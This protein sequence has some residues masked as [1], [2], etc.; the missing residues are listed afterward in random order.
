MTLILAMSKPEGV[1]MSVDYRVTDMRSG[2]LVDDASIKFLP[3]RYPPDKGGPRALLAY[4][5][6]ARLS[7]GT[8]MGT[9]IRESLRGETEVFDQSMAHLA[10][11]L[12]RDI[13]PAKIPLIINVFVIAGDN[14]Y[15]GGFTNLKRD[16]RNRPVLKKSFGYSLVEMTKPMAFVNGSGGIRALRDGHFDQMRAQLRVKPRRVMDHM[17]LLA[18]ANRRV[19][20]KDDSV[21][22]FCH[23][24]F[25][26]A[27]ESEGFKS[28]TFSEKGESVPFEMPV[29]LFGIDL[30][31]LL[32]DFNRDFAAWKAGDETALDRN[33]DPVEMNE[34]LKRRL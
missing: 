12:E 5:G 9:W 6:L 13:M 20:A 27:D 22:P 19:A 26:P 15:F 16:A 31:E 28:H 24:T 8:P 17:K 18:T 14:R 29:L 25:M 4:T 7:D 21:S 32:R 3:I 10:A 11:R 1:Y 2:R 23:V 30:T 34:R 33:I